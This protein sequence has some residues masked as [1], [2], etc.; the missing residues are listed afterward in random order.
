MSYCLTCWGTFSPTARSVKFRTTSSSQKSILQS[1]TLVTIFQNHS[2]REGFN[3][4]FFMVS[5]LTWRKFF[6]AF[7]LE[8]STV[9]R[10]LVEV[11]WEGAYRLLECSSS[12]DFF[13]WRSPSL[14]ARENQE[15]PDDYSIEE[16]RPALF[17]SLI[18]YFYITTTTTTI[19]TIGP[20]SWMAML[21]I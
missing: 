20:F 12:R 13:H 3:L 11:G 1:Q 2:G 21:A 6:R 14:L 9:L 4:E 19:A 17:L 5:L 18:Y 10:T 8:A 15:E 16:E 7:V